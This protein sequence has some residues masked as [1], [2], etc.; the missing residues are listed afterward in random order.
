MKDTFQGKKI[1][2]RSDR[3]DFPDLAL[4]EITAKIDTGA[5]TSSIHCKDIKEV[6]KQLIATFLDEDHPQYNGKQIVFDDYEITSVK[7]SNGQT[8]LRY[9]VKTKIKLFGKS[10]KISLTLASRQEM[11]FPVLLGRK[12]LTNK[13]IVDTD[14]KDVSF[15]TTNDE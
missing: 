2:G 4:K 3:V 12:F 14:L 15:I 1:I 11:R 8:E 5:Y 9:E 7:S 13:F 10:Y 6:D